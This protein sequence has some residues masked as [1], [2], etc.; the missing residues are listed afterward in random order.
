MLSGMENDVRH[1]GST[2][3]FRNS[4]LTKIQKMVYKTT[5]K[6]PPDLIAGCSQAGA[7]S[8]IKRTTGIGWGRRS[9]PNQTNGKDLGT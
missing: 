3:Y 8:L 5:T 6:H 2:G 7:R 9:F 4:Q 1:Q